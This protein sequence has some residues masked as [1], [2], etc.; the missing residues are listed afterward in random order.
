MRNKREQIR[1]AIVFL[2]PVASLIICAAPSLTS[3][4]LAYAQAKHRGLHRRLLIAAACTPR[5]VINRR[6]EFEQQ[7]KTATACAAATMSFFR[8]GED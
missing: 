7:L 3:S 8:H 1:R 5:S 4:G 2:L 6:E